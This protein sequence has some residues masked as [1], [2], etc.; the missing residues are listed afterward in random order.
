MFNFFL[1]DSES[2]PSSLYDKMEIF[3]RDWGSSTIYSQGSETF[4]HLAM[5]FF[6]LMPLGPHEFGELCSSFSYRGPSVS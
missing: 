1:V 6:I 5:I 2:A 3:I 4:F